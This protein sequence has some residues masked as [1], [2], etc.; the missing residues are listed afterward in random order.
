MHR[1]RFL[2]I[3][4]GTGGMVALGAGATGLSG[5]WSRLS[6]GTAGEPSA[7]DDLVRV[8]HG[9]H[10][11]GTEMWLRVLHRDGE[12]ATQAAE[13]AVGGVLRVEAVMSVYRAESDLARL[14][15]RGRVERP[16]PYLVEILNTAGRVSEQTN[17]AFDV[18]VQPLWGL[19][20]EAARTGSLP[21]QAE[22]DRVRRR[23]DWRQIEVR[24]ERIRLLGRDM[25]LTLNGI[26]QGFATDRA[27]AVLRQRGIEHA[28]VDA[29]EIGPM[30]EKA[31]GQAW[32]AGIQHPRQADAYVAVAQLDGRCLATSGDYATS[33]IGCQDGNA[34][35][36]PSV[37]SEN[38]PGDAVPHG[39]T[40]LRRNSGDRRVHHLFDPQ[41]GRSPGH[42]ASVSVLA[43]TATM[44]D[45]LSTAFSILPPPQMMDLVRE[46][47][48][49]DV[50]AVLKSGRVLSTP[51]FPV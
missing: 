22:L 28:L 13:A 27:V 7:A 1:R 33:L 19:Y 45:A 17:G 36:V 38:R 39:S 31:P 14:N 42:Y 40:Y 50:L 4:L 10:A 3:A 24:P 44:A 21:T 11:F 2:R 5:R 20:A 30:G 41:T 15:R 9:F 51:G 8:M 48:R 16:D 43:P 25:A 26:A 6:R 49:V 29:G 34:V 37:A 18:S 12:L 46:T 35:A 32:K 23:I 47:H